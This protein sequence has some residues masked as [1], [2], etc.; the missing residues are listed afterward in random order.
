MRTLITIL[1]TLALAVQLHGKPL[2]VFLLAGQSNNKGRSEG[3]ERTFDCTFWLNKPGGLRQASLMRF[4]FAG[5]A[6]GW[7]G[8]WLHSR[9]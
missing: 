4:V 2:K 3:E 7:R 6:S 8:A 5:V 1:T 9:I